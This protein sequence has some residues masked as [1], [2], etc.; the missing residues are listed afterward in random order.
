MSRGVGSLRR[1]A[2][3]TARLRTPPTLSVSMLKRTPGQLDE[4]L[5]AAS[6]AQKIWG[7]TKLEERS[8]ILNAIGNELQ[9]RA[10]EL[11]ELLSREEGKPPRRGDG[12]G[13]SRR[14]ILHLLRRRSFAT[15]GGDRRFRASGHRNRHSPR[16][17]GS[18]RH[19]L[20]VELS[21]SPPPAGRLLL[22]LPSATALCGSRQTSRLQA[23][24]AS[25][26]SSIGTICLRERSISSWEKAARSESISPRVP[27]RRAFPSRALSRR[28]ERSRRGPVSAMTKLQMEMGAKKRPWSLLTMPIA[29]SLSPAPCRGAFGGTGQ[30]CTASSR[31]IV[32]GKNL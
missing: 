2:S 15:A 10:K 25:P 32:N 6:D 19:R 23:P 12:R 16:T 20:A 30:K 9:T 7:N 31:L 3:R 8:D 17:L 11:G 22:P 13:L 4:A 1:R 26:R 24:S 27:R 5:D 14:T 21:R 18:G 28:E 29:T